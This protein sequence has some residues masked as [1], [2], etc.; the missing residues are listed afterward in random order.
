MDDRLRQMLTV[1]GSLVIII[2]VIGW[3]TLRVAPRPTAPTPVSAASTQVPSPDLGPLMPYAAPLS[4]SAM[5][6][7]RQADSVVVRRDPF[8]DAGY[9]KALA[10]RPRIGDRGG[11][12]WS[13]G[14]WRVSATLI[15][16]ARRAAVINDALV[17]EGDA[18]PGGGKLTSVERDRV[19][20]TDPHGTAHTVTVKEGDG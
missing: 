17:Y 14:E 6:V 10:S 8:F 9:A 12:R 15:G 19:V 20:V 13:A 2:G 11:S 5:I 16:G 3:R 4:D 7:P 1:G 18:V